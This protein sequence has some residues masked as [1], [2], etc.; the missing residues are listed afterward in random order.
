MEVLSHPLKPPAALAELTDYISDEVSKCEETRR[1]FVLQTCKFKLSEGGNF[2]HQTQVQGVIDPLAALQASH[3]P[4]LVF[5][6]LV[7]MA[8]V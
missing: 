8:A 6:P 7:S 5:L 1:L 3:F 2:S 4:R